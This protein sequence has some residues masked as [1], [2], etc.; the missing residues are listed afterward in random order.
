MRQR[1][2][3][4]VAWEADASLLAARLRRLG[5]PRETS[6]HIHANRTVMVSANGRGGV[7]VHR[8]YAYAPDQVLQAIVTF[9]SPG[10][11]RSDRMAARRSLVA[12]PVDRYVA[13]ARKRPGVPARDWKAVERL[14]AAHERLNR[15]HFGGALAT[16][17]VRLSGRMTTCLGAVAVD[18]ASGAVREI[19]MNRRHVERDPWELVED[20]LLHEMVHQWQ[21]EG[22]HAADHGRRFKDK[23]A[24]VGIIPAARSTRAAAEQCASHRRRT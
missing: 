19:V 1:P 7:R 12:F 11:R 14:Q 6:V 3:E 17:P 8:G 24:A 5:L 2:A 20:T 15:L 4:R 22:G 21:V 13:S 9:L 16:M 23:A 10:A 18:A